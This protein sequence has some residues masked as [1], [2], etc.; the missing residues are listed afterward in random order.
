MRILIF[1][2]Y[3]LRGTGSNVY[4]ARLAAALA[5]RGAIVDLLSQERRA[6]EL[7][8]VD[9]VGTWVD[10]EPRVDVIREPVRVTAWRPDIGDLLPVYV[11]DRYEGVVAKPFARLHR[12]G[13]RRVRGRER[14]RSA[15]RRRP[16]AARRRARQPPRDGPARPRPRARRRGA[17][18]GEDPRQRARVHRQARPRAV[19]A[20]RPRGPRARA[21]GPRRLAAHGREP[22]GRDGRR[23]P[24]GAHAARAAGRRH[25]GVPPAAARRGGGG[26]D[27]ARDAPGRGRLRRSGTTPSPATR[28]PSAARCSGSTS[29]PAATATSRS[30][31][32]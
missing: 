5:R 12:R 10:G 7:D 18:R 15:R 27:G 16:G 24:A 14:R 9:A 6:R 25:R 11:A 26:G 21:H 1:H 29:P 17:L 19:P 2:G 32:S 31:A 3:L 8:F 28:R 20:R 23:R 30:W 4:N 22:L 13:D